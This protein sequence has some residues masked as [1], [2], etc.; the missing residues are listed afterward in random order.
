LL[1]INN[2][3]SLCLMI[4]VFTVLS[5]NKLRIPLEG[6]YSLSIPTPEEYRVTRV[7]PGVT[8]SKLFPPFVAS[9]G[10]LSVHR[11]RGTPSKGQRVHT[12][13]ERERER[14]RESFIRNNLHNGVVSGAAR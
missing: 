3:L 7:N 10:Q 1:L 9:Q 13:R 6:T 14:E 4:V 11:D 2:T 8:A 5:R 12:E